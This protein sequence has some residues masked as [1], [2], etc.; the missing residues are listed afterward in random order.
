MARAAFDSRVEAAA[1]LGARLAR[2]LGR[3]AAAV[4]AGGGAPD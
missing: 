1:T 4:G 3:V 2:R